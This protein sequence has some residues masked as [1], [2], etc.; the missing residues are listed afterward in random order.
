MPVKEE[1]NQPAQP[2][3]KYDYK[4]PPEFPPSPSSPLA[5]DGRTICGEELVKAF[6]KRTSKKGL[7]TATW[8]PHTLTKFVP[9]LCRVEGGYQVF[10]VYTNKTVQCQFTFTDVKACL[11]LD[12]AKRSNRASDAMVSA[13]AKVKGGE[14]NFVMIVYGKVMEETV[15]LLFQSPR[16]RDKFVSVVMV[17]KRSLEEQKQASSSDISDEI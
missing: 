3:S 12:Q 9:A 11:T 6:L 4:P 5:D 8:T 14:P 1:V 2:K 17:L 7:T 15:P 10:A 16:E 13:L